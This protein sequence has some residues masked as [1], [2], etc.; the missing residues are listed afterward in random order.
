MRRFVGAAVILAALAT[1]AAAQDPV[2]LGLIDI[3]SG[4]FAF[5]ADSIR[6][7]FQIAV[8]EANAAGGLKGRKFEV[9]TADMGG[10]V[11]KAV[12]EARRMI[13]EE[14]IKYVTVG[15]HSGAAVAVGNLGKEHKV[16][17]NGGFATTKRLTGEA[18]HDYVARANLSTVEIGRVMAE[19]LK[20]RPDVKRIAVI[21]PDYEY[22]QHF[23]ADFIAGV[24][25]ARP[26]ITVVRQEMH[27]LGA[28][29]FGPHVTAL[30][31]QPVDLVVGGM[32]G[33]DLVNFLRS[34]RDFGLFSGKT[35]FFT[36]GLDL[37][38]MGALKDSL[39]PNTMGTVWYPFYAINTPKSKSFTAEIE[40]RMKTYPTGSTT[41]GY[42]AGKML[43]EGIRKAG[44]DDVEAVRKA[45]G[46]VQFEGPTGMTKVRACD[47][48][49]L[50]NFY[51]GNVKR[52]ASLPDGIGMGDVKAINTES[53]ARSCDEVKKARATGG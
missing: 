51:V 20:S 5:I 27:K 18:G 32:F 1:P 6:N 41:V 44:T 36:H 16:L 50:Y 3:Y 15:I 31:A 21:A 12:T 34:A 40:K 9:V 30:Q 42:V 13:L 35:Q 29:D 39:P 7:G 11:D 26:D 8:D 25:V 48:M 38:K 23:V 53:V 52:D 24:K 46:T 49:A 28:T 19:H 37:A 4:G 14:K 33:A 47:N 10:S 45:L 22:G 2:K 43:V 17:I